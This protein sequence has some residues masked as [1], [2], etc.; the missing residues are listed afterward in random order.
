MRKITYVLLNEMSKEISLIKEAE[1]LLH[2][3]NYREIKTIARKL[4]LRI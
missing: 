2:W 4:K 1:M 3:I